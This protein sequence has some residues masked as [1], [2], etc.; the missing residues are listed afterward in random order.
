MN[1]TGAS[2]V[3][4]REYIK[5]MIFTLWKKMNKETHTSSFSEGFKDSIINLTRMSL[6]M[7]QHGDGHTIQDS[8][9]Q[10][11]VMLLIFKNIPIVCTKQ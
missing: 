1:E 3:E 6:C 2:E 8:Q 11:H 5:S 9:I 7:Y 4:A 10:N